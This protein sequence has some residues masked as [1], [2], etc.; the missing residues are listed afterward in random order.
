MTDHTTPDPRNRPVNPYA[1]PQDRQP[2]PSNPYAAPQP[3]YQPQQAQFQPQAHSTASRVANTTVAALQEV[4][5]TRPGLISTVLLWIGAV[6]GVLA[7]LGTFT[8]FGDS[9]TYA[10]GGLCISAAVTLACAWP[11]SR[12]HIDRKALTAWEE[13]VR[14]NRELSAL[15]TEE[16]AAIAAGLAPAP[17]PTPVPRHWKV[18]GAATVLLVIV[19]GALVG[20]GQDE[21]DKANPPTYGSSTTR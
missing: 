15:L 3:Q 20:A 10:L 13:D 7:F 14:R 6:C 1:V 18:V 2:G 21:Y 12:R 9:V 5:A 17:R 4:H 8:E 11:L 16:D 19:G